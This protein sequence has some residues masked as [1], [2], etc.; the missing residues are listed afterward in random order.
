MSAFQERL[1]M[2]KDESNRTQA[3]IAE[4]IG[5]T[6]QAFSNY[7]N[8]REPNFDT[9]IK[10]AKYFHV[11]VDW[12]LG[13]SDVKSFKSE[14]RSICDY[15]GLSQEAV[16]ELRHNMENTDSV[17]VESNGTPLLQDW[18]SY[19]ICSEEAENFGFYCEAIESARDELETAIFEYKNRIQQLRDRDWSKITHPYKSDVMFS[20]DFDIE[21]ISDEIQKK[22]HGLYKV[23]P[24][25]ESIQ[26]RRG[27]IFEQLTELL[28]EVSGYDDLLALWNEER[29]LE[30]AA[31]DDYFSSRPKTGGGKRSDQK[32]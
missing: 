16:E 23:V 18:I 20:R 29:K 30:I 13:L 25:K 22:T 12:L 7:M 8:G 32:K 6:P 10:M 14:V 15:T 4:S 28:D 19:L 21:L 2:L 31:L 11:S 17:P 26:T 3:Q 24:V 5:L 1:K 9:L 27:E